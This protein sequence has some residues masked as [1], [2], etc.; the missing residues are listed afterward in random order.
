MF[1]ALGTPKIL[2]SIGQES[3]DMAEAKLQVEIA[4]LDD[5]IIRLLEMFPNPC[6]S[7]QTKQGEEMPN[8]ETCQ[9]G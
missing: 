2:S 8:C 4:V 9:R 6:S 7:R 1:Y 3:I 5:K